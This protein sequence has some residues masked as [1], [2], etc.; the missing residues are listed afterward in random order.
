ME[1]KIKVY[2]TDE[3]MEILV[4]TNKS[5]CRFGD[6]ELKLICDLNYNIGFQPNNV[7]LQK[8]LKSILIEKP[9]DDI[10]VSIVY[11]EQP[12]SLIDE[13][14]RNFLLE[15]VKFKNS[16]YK[17]GAANITRRLNYI[18]QFK[19]IWNNKDV[20]IIEGEYTRSGVGNDLFD[21]AKS[22]KRI[23]CPATNAFKKYYEI[24]NYIVEN[25]TKDNLLLCSLGPTATILSYDLSKLGYRI[26]DIGHLDI[27]YEWRKIGPEK[28]IIK[29]KYVNEVK[30]GSD[31]GKI[32]ECIDQ[33]YII[34]IM[35]T[36]I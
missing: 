10:L 20:V 24:Y 14:K 11:L 17:F 23:I 30:G 34:Q 27:I 9:N 12:N 29:G 33:N 1:N 8:R 16:N 5:I 31:I 36:I 6:G 13:K 18:P 19:K 25:I 28:Y 35:K 7:E 32:G 2:S 21:N 15:L 22:I 4:N 3:T 26:L